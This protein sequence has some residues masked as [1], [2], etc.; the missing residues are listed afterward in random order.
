GY[1]GLEPVKIASEGL[2]ATGSTLGTFFANLDASAEIIAPWSAVGDDFTHKTSIKAFDTL[3]NEVIFDVYFSKTAENTWQMDVVDQDSGTVIQG[4]ISLT[5]DTTTGELDAASLAAASVVMP[6]TTA[7]DTPPNMLEMTLD[8]TSLTQLNY[9]FTIKAEVDGN[10]PS[11]VEKIQIAADGIVYAQYKNGD[12]LPMYRLAMATVQS[13][14][15]LRVISGNVYAQSNDSGIVILGFPGAN[16]MGAVVS[17]ALESSTVDIAEELTRMI[18]SQRT[19]T[20][21]SKVFQTG[22]DLMDV[23]VNLKR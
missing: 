12:L 6:A 13:P 17:G 5:F 21:N 1:A 15:Q 14:D 23:L 7:A 9:D 16:G 2:I 19:Y 11:E 3:G 8:F 18:E 20:A 22:S 4:G 10:A